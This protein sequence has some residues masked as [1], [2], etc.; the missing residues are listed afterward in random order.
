[1]SVT[2]SSG[3]RSAARVHQRAARRRE[4]DHARGHVAVQRRDDDRRPRSAASARISSRG[5][6]AL[7]VTSSP[8]PSSIASR[9]ASGRS[10]TTTT[11]PGRSRSGASRRPSPAPRL[12]RDL[13][14]SPPPR[15]R[16]RARRR[17]RPRPWARRAR[18][19]ARLA[20]VAARQRALGHDAHE[21]AVVVDDR[22][23]V[24]V[25][26]RHQQADLADRLAVVGHREALAHHVA[27]AQHHVR[28]ELGLGAPLRSSTQR[29]CGVE[30]AQ[31]APARTRCA[32]R[33]A[34]SAPRSR[35]P[36]RSSPCPGCGGR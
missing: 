34:A 13:A 26:A 23:Q 1:M 15:A 31:A 9:W 17:S 10:P 25:L 14:S 16:P 22:H 33:A 4:R 28:Q 29:V 7:L 18:G 2:R 30:L 21:R 36:T 35:S 5:S 6:V 20:D 3:A 24:E 12:G 19:L 8:A 27:H 32:G 11:S